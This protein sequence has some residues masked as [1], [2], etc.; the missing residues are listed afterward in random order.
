MNP[1]TQSPGI[2]GAWL[3]AAAIAALLACTLL[4]VALGT[5]PIP[6]LEAFRC[7]LSGIGLY[8]P[9][10]LNAGRRAAVLLIRLPRVLAGGLAGAGLATAGAVMQGVFRNPLAEPG[11]LGVSAGA[12][13]GA[14][15]AIA[16]GAASFALLPL[17]AFAGAM[18]AMGLILCVSARAGGGDSLGLV[19][20]GMAVGALFAAMTSLLLAY[21]N[22]YQVANYIFW[23]MGGLA[24]RRWQHLALLAPP[25]LATLAVLC[26]LARRLDVLLLGD[27]QA[28]ALGVRPGGTRTL[29]VSLAS[30]C[31]A[32]VVAVTGPIGFIGLIV[33][34]VARLLIGPIHRRLL[35]CSALG[36]AIFLML[37]DLLVRVIGIGRGLELS[38]GIITAA[39]GAPF[40]LAL[41]WRRAREGGLPRD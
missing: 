6:P 1:K 19:L 32:S 11:V 17:Y 41:L 20:S 34:H 23:T 39:L 9:E 37:C 13:L 22:E 26:A 7:L 21:S 27:E 31:A 8:P 24:N 4:C 16:T 28:R 30:L 14:L 18:L 25:V 5:V 12:G 15:L 2:R 38:V 10:A 40:F 35:P 3:G 29:L 33:P 36:G